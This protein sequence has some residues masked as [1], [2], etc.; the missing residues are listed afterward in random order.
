MVGEIRAHQDRSHTGLVAGQTEAVAQ[1]ADDVDERILRIVQEQLALIIGPMAGVL[2]KRAMRRRRSLY[3]L[4]AREI[5][6]QQ[7]RER[8]LSGKDSLH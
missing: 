4:L 8:F 2:V 1:Q 6:T 7:K 3:P 5:P